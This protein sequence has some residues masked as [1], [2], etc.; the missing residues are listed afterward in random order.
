RWYEQAG[1]PRLAVHD[2]YDEA[3]RSY[4]LSVT[5]RCAPTPGQPEKA[6][7]HI[8]LALA[9]IGP[10]GRELPLRVEGERN[11]RGT[12]TVL[13]LRQETEVFR[14]LDVPSR[15]V[16]SLARNF[17][18]PV[19]VEYAYDEASLQ[20]LLAYDSDPFNRWEAGQRLAMGLLLQGV[21]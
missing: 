14:F 1:T 20:H 3:T 12:S 11:G 21:A 9:L 2:R 7:L 13:S 6:P 4:E 8:P 17:S 18:A 16:P 19:V 5:Q 10:T 15:P